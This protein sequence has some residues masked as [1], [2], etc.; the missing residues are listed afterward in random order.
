VLGMALR[1]KWVVRDADGRALEITPHG[2]REMQAL[3]GISA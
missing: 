3:L 1:R 2:R